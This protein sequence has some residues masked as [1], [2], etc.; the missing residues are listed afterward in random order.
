MNTSGKTIPP[1]PDIIG[2][3][4]F[5]PNVNTSTSVGVN[6]AAMLNNNARTANRVVNNNVN[7]FNPINNARTANNVVTNNVNAFNPINNTNN[8]KVVNSVN[9][10]RFNNNANVANQVV[11]SMPK[12][13]NNT[14]ATILAPSKSRS[15]SKSAKSQRVPTIVYSN[16]DIFG[17]NFTRSANN[18]GCVI[19]KLLKDGV[20]NPDGTIDVTQLDPEVGIEKKNLWLYIRYL[21]SVN[22]ENTDVKILS[23][24]S[25][26]EA[27][28]TTNAK[29]FVQRV[30]NFARRYNNVGTQREVTVEDAVAL[31]WR[32]LVE[33]INHVVEINID[34]IKVP[35]LESIINVVLKKLKGDIQDGE[36]TQSRTMSIPIKVKYYSNTN[37]DGNPIVEK[38]INA[39]ADLKNA[40]EVIIKV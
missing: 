17:T 11:R 32:D 10:A 8:V 13:V 2:P 26:Q 28:G 25:S 40:L 6:N 9:A 22:H 27:P 18:E 30:F 31:N 37:L 15:K 5:V 7:A 19:A 1:T 14:F 36:G 33:F 29:E 35:V 23:E 3:N 4:D 16:S 39:Q 24:I 38:E 20:L 12:S 34:T 21:W